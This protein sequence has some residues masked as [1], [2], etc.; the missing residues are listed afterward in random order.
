MCI[1]VTHFN[2][3]EIMILFVLLIWFTLRPGLKSLTSTELS[4]TAMLYLNTSIYQ[5]YAET[6]YMPHS[7]C[8]LPFSETHLTEKGSFLWDFLGLF[9]LLSSTFFITMFAS[10]FWK[11]SCIKTQMPS[12]SYMSCILFEKTFYSQSCLFS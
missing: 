3:G 4:R 11:E 7:Q 8:W 10:Q 1:T 2:T 6:H 5:H 9:W 12:P